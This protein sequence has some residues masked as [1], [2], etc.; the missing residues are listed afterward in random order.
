MRK[1]I[2]PAIIIGFIFCN[3]KKAI[4]QEQV[5]DN[6]ELIEMFKNDQ[7]D[8]T[9]HFDWSI[10]QKNDSIREARVYELLDSNK[11]RTSTDYTNAALIFHHGEDSVAYGMAMKLIRKS[12]ELDPTRDKWFL[13]VITDR[14]LLSINK[15]QIYG[16][17]YKRFENNLVVRE[18]MDS[19]I[20]TD[21]ERIEC[22]VET[23]AEQREKIK[24]LNRKKLTELLDEGKSIDEIIL[25][26]KQGD[27]KKS[28]Y[29]LRENWINNFGYQLMNQGKKEQAITAY[30][31][32]LELNP[33]NKHAEEV[34]SKMK[35]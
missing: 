4:A 3:S 13:A 8:R 12:I 18:E 29:D 31:K 28:Q 33:E 22:K 23:L 10:I 2:L 30:K 24:N 20:I 11:V 5:T 14:Y 6:H 26:V 19:T 25:I 15:P 32:S 9:N 27:V 34:L 21:A 35:E 16:T 1:I 17:Q 7:A